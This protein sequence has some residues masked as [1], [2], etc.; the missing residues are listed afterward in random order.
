MLQ[1][2][3]INHDELARLIKESGTEGSGKKYQIVD[4]RDEDFSG[5][6]M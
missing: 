3:Y 4:V 6:N 5:G 1:Y 2:R